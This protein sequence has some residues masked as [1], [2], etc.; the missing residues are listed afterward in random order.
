MFP[1]SEWFAVTRP[2]H[3]MAHVRQAKKAI[4]ELPA[5]D[6]VKAIEQICIWLDCIADNFDIKSD[7]RFQLIDLLDQ[8]ARNHQR[9]ISEEYMSGQRLLKIRENMLWDTAF[10]FS[11][12]LSAGYNQCVEDF[13]SAKRGTPALTTQLPAII[14][15]AMRALRFQLKWSLM[16]YGPIDDRIWGDLGRLYNFA[17]SQRIVGA[18]VE[19]Y[20]SP[21]TQKRSSVQQE[22]L[23]MMMLRVSSMDA[24]N[25]FEQDIVERTVEQ[26]GSHFVLHDKPTASCT[27]SFDLSMRK[28]PARGKKDAKS[29][30]DV[31]YFGAGDSTIELAKLIAEA[32]QKDDLPADI[33]SKTMRDA[34]LVLKVLEHLARYWSGLPPSRRSERHKRV[35]RLSVAPSLTGL[36]NEMI[37]DSNN[38]SLDFTQTESW[39]VE[40]AND[41]GYGAIIPHEKGDWIRVG[42][43]VGLQS[44]TGNGW[45]AGIIRR[46]SQHK[47]VGIELLSTF[48]S[49]VIVSFSDGSLTETNCDS[50]QAVLISR[51][52][53]EYG[54]IT[55]LLP[56][57][58]FEPEQNLN[59][60]LRG[61]N[62]QLLPSK[63]I[64]RGND[65][66]C[67]QF[68]MMQC[69]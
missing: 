65:F 5:T 41:G 40:D 24:L 37:T 32:R 49:P 51:N 9:K 66:D 16:R 67:A 62:Y 3:P 21:I 1:M 54:E 38:D 12:L 2:N 50:H 46:I 33:N 10:R 35:M 52:P 47:R 26:Y 48:A 44:E 53:D 18:I 60:L 58:T 56:A 59:M 25:L 20:P 36:F 23:K 63:V 13:Q 30:G 45:H 68:A 11:K 43:L 4:S 7:R 55:L 42:T 6:S 61:A 34:D 31:R 8:A 29:V 14:A 39:I 57:D 27:F 15:R 28:S 64:E 69:S 19:V 22:F 17:E